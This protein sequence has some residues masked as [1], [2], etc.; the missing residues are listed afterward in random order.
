M[1][2]FNAQD[3]AKIAQATDEKELDFLLS[4]IKKSAHVYKRTLHVYRPISEST[5]QELIT[6]GFKI[7]DYPS[8]ATRRNSLYHSISW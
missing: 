2:T 4:Q 5:R 1:N 8:I 6:R 7:F 3:A